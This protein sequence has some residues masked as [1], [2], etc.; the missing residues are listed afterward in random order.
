MTAIFIALTMLVIIQL[1]YPV[2]TIAL[3]QLFGKESLENDQNPEKSH[4]FACIITAYKNA[5]IALPLVESL[6][7]QSYKEFTI[8]L[9]ADDCK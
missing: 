3:A 4:H 7:R 2:V 5:A 6:L 8:Y 9:V 1:I